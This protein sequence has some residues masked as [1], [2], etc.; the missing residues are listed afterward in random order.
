[1]WTLLFDS[2]IGAFRMAYFAMM[3]SPI[4]QIFIGGSDTGVHVIKF[5]DQRESVALFVA[6]VET[7]SG[8]IAEPNGAGSAE[9]IYQ[10]RQ[11]FNHQR[12]EFELL[13]APRG[14]EFQLRVWRALRGIP[15]GETMSYGAIAKVIGKPSAFRAVGGA[16]RRNPISIVVPCHR[17]IGADGTPTGY[18]GGLHRK[19]WLLEHELSAIA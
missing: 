3:D 6:E 14:T 18:A 9:S 11:Y 2:L 7:A 8:E 12:D 5:A 10:L 1:M 13:L 15:A 19:I 17:V 4:G 16:N